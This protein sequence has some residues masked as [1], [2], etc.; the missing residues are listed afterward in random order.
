MYRKAI[1]ELFGSF[2]I[3]LLLGFVRSFSDRDFII[4]ALTT[5]MVYSII[6]HML[7]NT[8]KA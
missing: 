3:V 8:S 5:F 7:K 6:V 1:F 2:M 4:W